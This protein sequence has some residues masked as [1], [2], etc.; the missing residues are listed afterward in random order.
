MNDRVDDAAEGLV[1]VHWHVEDDGDGEWEFDAHLGLDAGDWV[2]YGGSHPQDIDYESPLSVVRRKPLRV[3]FEPGW[4]GGYFDLEDSGGR[5]RFVGSRRVPLH[6]TPNFRDMGGYLGADG[7]RVRWGR[8]FRSGHLARLDE[9]DQ[10]H[11]SALRLRLVC[12]FRR[13][14]EQERQPARF[15]ADAKPRLESLSITPGSAVSF[16]ERMREQFQSD[17]VST[18]DT[19]EFMRGVNRDL[20]AEHAG[21]YAR[22]FDLLMEMEDGA[23]LINCTAGKDRTGFGAAMI[24]AALGVSK[25][26]IVEDY[27]LSNRFINFSPNSSWLRALGEGD[28]D[29]ANQIDLRSILEVRDDY[30]GSALALIDAEYGGVENYLERELGMD[31]SRRE[32]FQRKFLQPA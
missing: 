31:A 18:A 27:L 7:R 9:D 2:V 6:G 16:F 19:R 23:A 3:R 14:D 21:V 5:R 17:K 30:L 24:L 25:R 4:R 28:A 8:L 32:E 1:S 20:V 29:W 22:M 13:E 10:R 12:D 15:A 26:D 11:L